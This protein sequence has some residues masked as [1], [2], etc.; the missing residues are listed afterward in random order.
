VTKPW[1]GQQRDLTV[2][3]H[4]PAIPS[5]RKAV[6]AVDEAVRRIRSVIEGSPVSED[7]VHSLNTLDWILRLVP[8]A[9]E[10]LRLAALGH[11]IER[12]VSSQR[13]K[14]A[15]F[16]DFDEFKAA[17]A[18]NSARILREVLEECGLE[19]SLIE[20]VFRLVCLH[21]TGGDQRSDLLRD[22]DSLSFFEVNLPYYFARQ[23][24]EA[25]L[26]RG[27]WGYKR[28]SPES[29]VVVK[30]FTYTDQRLNALVQEIAMV[31]E[32]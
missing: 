21:E 11:D 29:R 18:K 30:G 25:T 2:G 17:H 1:I 23:G 7:P 15:D 12:S 13:I 19:E 9:D 27:I 5:I 16:N 14:K 31:A 22:A 32:E 3:H 28:L 8:R 26:R 24:M 10:A 20:E 6:S 4:H